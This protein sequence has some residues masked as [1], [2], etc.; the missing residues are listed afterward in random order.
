MGRILVGQSSLSGTIESYSERFGLVEVTPVDQP[1]PQGARLRSWRKKAPP[2]FVFS[3]VLPQVVG[4]LTASPEGEVALVESLGAA[5]LLEA[6]AVVL[7]TPPS[8]R[9]TSTNKKRIE[10]VLGRVPAEGVL[11]AWEP[12]GLWEREEAVSFARSIGV[13]CVLDGTQDKL[14]AGPTVYTRLRDAGGRNLS[15]GALDGLAKQLAGRRE[16]FVVIESPARGALGEEVPR[17]ARGAAPGASRGGAGPAP[18]AR[19][20]RR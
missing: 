4:A 14:P 8:V 10:A 12:S 13:A 16:A 20:A 18:L 19:R 1:L 9:P 3:V 2:G 11:R 17:R 7:R 5:R 6:R 15:S